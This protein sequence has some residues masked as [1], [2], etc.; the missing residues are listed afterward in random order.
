MQ[1]DMPTYLKL[2]RVDTDYPS[3]LD[4]AL[5]T[6]FWSEPASEYRIGTLTESAVPTLLFW[7]KK[8]QVQLP[9]YPANRSTLRG[10]V[11]LRLPWPFLEGLQLCFPQISLLVPPS[12]SQATSKRWMRPIVKPMYLGLEQAGHDSQL[13][14]P[15]FYSGISGE[16]FGGLWKGVAERMASWHSISDGATVSV[17]CTDRVNHNGC[18]KT[19]YPRHMLNSRLVSL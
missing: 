15:L 12:W 7:N 2:F 13:N 10:R 18:Y 1:E 19:L 17:R 8:T 9:R 4:Q 16:A 6:V 5:W 14:C 11:T 3:P